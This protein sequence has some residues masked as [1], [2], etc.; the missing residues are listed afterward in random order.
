MLLN[1]SICGK[2]LDKRMYF[3]HNLDFRGRAYPMS[4]HFS[5]IGHDICRGLLQFAEA[6]PLGARGLFWLKVHVANMVGNDKISL[7]DRAAF[8]E[9]HLDD[10]FDSSDHP[11]KVCQRLSS[12][13]RY[14]SL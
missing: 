9:A 10:V 6:R 1:A 7:D 4:P 12:C 8:T 3:P 11:L 14:T 5:H 2:F 13:C